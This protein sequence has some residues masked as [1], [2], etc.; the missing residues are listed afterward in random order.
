MKFPCRVPRSL[1]PQRRGRHVWFPNLFSQRWLFVPSCCS[2]G[3]AGACP[4]GEAVA[5]PVQ[6][7]CGCAWGRGG[8][9]NTNPESSGTGLIRDPAV[10]LATTPKCRA[11]LQN[12]GAQVRAGVGTG[13]PSPCTPGCQ[14]P[15][16]FSLE[17]QSCT[18]RGSCS[19]QP[20]QRSPG[21]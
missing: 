20:A 6:G 18:E 8:S 19:A 2:E 3:C 4:V 9:A 16:G 5:A 1:R 13:T 21:F 11:G 15:P 17:Q 14:A 10:C 7:A 12:P